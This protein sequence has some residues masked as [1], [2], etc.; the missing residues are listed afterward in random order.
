MDYPEPYRS[1]ILDYL[2]KPGLCL[3][4]GEDACHAAGL[5]GADVLPDHGGRKRGRRGRRS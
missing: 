4:H 5:A 1:R 3:P 2:F